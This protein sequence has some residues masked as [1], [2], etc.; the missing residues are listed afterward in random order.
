MAT[1]AETT[2]RLTPDE[3]TTLPKG[4]PLHA[5]LGRL[6]R[7]NPIG[8][9]ALLVVVAFVALGIIGPSIAP[10]DP[11]ALN[12]R[13]QYLGPSGTHL[14]GT[15]QFGFDVFSRVLAGARIDLKF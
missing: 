3:Y 2:G 12:A 6:A 15:T 1:L 14:F 13:E 8:T 10:Y 11:K 7:D 9:L 4:K 5:K